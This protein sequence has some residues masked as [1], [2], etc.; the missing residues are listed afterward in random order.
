MGGPTED[1][2]GTAL[3][4]LLLL[5]LL[6]ILVLVLVL[7]L[8]LGLVIVLVVAVAVA[9]AVAVSWGA[10]PRSLKASKKRILTP[11]PSPTCTGVAECVSRK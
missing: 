2:N 9:V 11:K 10:S 6:L 1:C 8:G 7:G 3:V 5:L 4:V